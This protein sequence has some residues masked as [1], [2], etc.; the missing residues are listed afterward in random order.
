MVHLDCGAATD[1]GRVRQTNEDAFFASSPV[2]VV[3]DGMGGHQAGDIASAIAVEGFARLAHDGYDTTKAP[4]V[5]TAA[6][7]ECQRRIHAYGEEHRNDG[8]GEWYAGTTVA[9]AV[10]C[11]DEEGAKWLLVNL[12]DSRIY[13]LHNG[14]LDQVSVDHSLV[15]ELLDSGEI[16]ADEAAHHP[17]R[18]VITRALGGPVFRDPDFFVLPLSSAERVVLCSDG[19][20]GMIDDAEIHRIVA[21]TDDPR[22]AAEA[23]VAAA[24]S[25]GGEDN[26]TA[27]VVDVVGLAESATPHMSRTEPVSLEEKLGALP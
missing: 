23:L 10:L 16:D 5:V 4:E 17:E 27:V 7:T 22:D 24:V 8:D 2:F 19:V 25:A 12:G 14:R 20:S 6:L 18:H 1:V 13:K 21:G 3:A 11:E 26:A 9:A 15:Q